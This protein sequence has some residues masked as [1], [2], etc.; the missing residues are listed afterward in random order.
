MVQELTASGVEDSV[1]AFLDACTQGRTREASNLL[2][3]MI[4]SGTNELQIVAMLQRQIRSLAGARDLMNR[5]VVDRSE[6]ARQLGLHP[7]PAG[8]AMASAR[9]MDIARLTELLGELV[10]IERRAKNGQGR[11]RAEIGLF[12]AKMKS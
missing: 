3:R 12:A 10:E 9:S 8:K 4:L 7:F 11:T 1:F 2:E 5:G 6:V